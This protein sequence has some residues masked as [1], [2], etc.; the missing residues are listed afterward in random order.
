MNS[1]IPMLEN[2][3][4][5]VNPMLSV[6]SEILSLVL[7]VE[8]VLVVLDEEVVVNVLEIISVGSNKAIL[9]TTP[10]GSGEAKVKSALV[11]VSICIGER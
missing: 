9:G 7:E 1:D 8:G 11:S 6:S 2:T 5:Y 4:K 10:L 3:M